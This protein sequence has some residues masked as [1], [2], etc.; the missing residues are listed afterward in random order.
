MSSGIRV[1]EI[2]HTE[3]E[4]KR[5]VEQ[6]ILKEDVFAVVVLLLCLGTSWGVGGWLNQYVNAAVAT[7]SLD[8]MRTG[9]GNALVAGTV[10]G[11]W[12]AVVIV[13]AVVG[14]AVTFGVVFGLPYYVL[15]RWGPPAPPC[16]V[17]HPQT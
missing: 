5:E 11:A 4:A 8:G 12:Y 6:G 7:V 3:R 15:S 13:G 14:F 16:V 1:T 10:L 17:C 9:V 2:H